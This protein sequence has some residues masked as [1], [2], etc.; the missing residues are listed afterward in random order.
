MSVVKRIHR[1]TLKSY[2]GPFI[3]TF[4]IAEFVLL[5]QFVWKYVDDLVGKGLE[6]SVILELMW[7]TSASLV[8]MALPIA[9][10]LSSIMT[11]GSM[12]ESLELVAIKSA[13]VSLYRLMRPLI[14]FSLFTALAAFYFSNNILP[15]ANLKTRSLI[16]DIQKQRPA[17]DIQP[18][19]FYNGIP[20]LVVR[21]DRVGKDK[22]T[23]G[24]VII[25]DHSDYSKG[26]GRVTLA[27]SGRIEV[28]SDDRYLLLAL[29]NGVTYD[30]LGFFGKRDPNLPEAVQHF[31]DQVILIDLSEFKL[32]R[33]SENLYKDHYQMMTISQLDKAMFDIRN[34]GRQRSEAY[35]VS[36][37]KTYFFGRKSSSSAQSNPFAAQD[38]ANIRS[39]NMLTPGLPNNNMKNMMES[40]YQVPV[41]QSDSTRPLISFA[42]FGKNDWM[43]ELRPEMQIQM[44][45]LA[46]NVARS[47]R[48]RAED[49]TNEIKYRNENLARHKTEWHRKFTLSVAC[50][51]LFFIGA[52]L[53]AIIKRGGLGLPL[54][55]ATLIF[56]AY[57]LLSTIGEKAAKSLTLTPFWGM[58]ISTLVLLPFG[59]LLT[60]MAANDSKIFERE[61]YKDLGKK[62]LFWRRW[63]K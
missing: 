3:L 44:Y 43:E 11:L 17:L 48:A 33:E 62:F 39:L 2:L 57:Y 26:N 36:M 63:K 30:E 25:Y 41:V 52:P 34:E 35:T 45:D 31:K 27:E 1:Y 19:V 4:F 53:G 7:Y 55:S 59:V 6:T 20:D 18:G 9:I 15:V 12:A 58:W 28:T 46:L 22:K 50:V 32:S 10:L 8:P 29:H 38:S 14:I 54:V 49:Y 23:L 47:N 5:M 40:R 51:L 21:V 61:T 56:I 37:R 13:G 42:E 60:Y 24:D 16:M